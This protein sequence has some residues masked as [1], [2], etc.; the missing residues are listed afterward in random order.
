MLSFLHPVLY[1]PKELAV[2]TPISINSFSR[3]Y[4]NCIFCFIYRLSP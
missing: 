1:T 3:I 4:H 2:H